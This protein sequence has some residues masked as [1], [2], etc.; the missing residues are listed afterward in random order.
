MSSV[1][2]SATPKGNGLQATVDYSYGIAVSSAETYPTEGEA[3][4]AAALKMLN[5]PKRLA[6]FD[7]ARTDA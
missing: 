3:I 2:L 5:L 4:A 7:A 6:E 1:T